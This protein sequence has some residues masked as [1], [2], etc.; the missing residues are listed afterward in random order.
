MNRHPLTLLVLVCLLV[1]MAGCAAK[2]PVAG[3]LSVS[4][5]SPVVPSVTPLPPAPSSTPTQVA[6]SATPT[7]TEQPSPTPTSTGCTLL[8]GPPDGL[9]ATF[10]DLVWDW[11]GVLEADQWF[12]VR[13]RLDQPGDPPITYYWVWE[14]RLRITSSMLAPGRYRWHVCVVRGDGEPPGTEALCPVPEAAERIFVLTGPSTQATL[15]VT[16]VA[17]AECPLNAVYNGN[18]EGGFSARG[19]ADV[20]VGNGWH[21]W[22]KEGPYQSQGYNKQP[23]Y[24]PADVSQLGGKRVYEGNFSQEWSSTDATHHAGVFHQIYVP[25]NSVVTVSA[26]AQAWSSEEDDPA[27]SEGGKYSMRVGIDPYGGIN[28]R[29]LAI[30]WSERDRTLDKWV[31]LTVQARARSNVVT[32]YLRG[33]A[34]RRVKHNNVYFDGV[35]VTHVIATPSPTAAWWPWPT[36]TSTPTPTTTST[37]T[38]SST[39]TPSA[40]GSLTPTYTLT[41]SATPSSTPSHT[42]TPS[43]TASL[44]R[45]NT[46]T[47]TQTETPVPTVPEPTLP[48]PTVPA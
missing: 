7:L 36:A 31:H 42:P 47:P 18:F 28:W 11:A 32:I 33:D 34:E 9:A 4:T 2:T 14:R 25:S 23:E 16:P 39:P 15:S 13:I 20:I 12:E 46:P 48:P 24:K 37:A 6:P 35:C 1:A 19:A 30:V 3:V 43:A 41:P 22:W 29:S 38:A 5:P 21:P 44:T 8:L 17:T 10:V 27:V 40:T 45:T 26:W